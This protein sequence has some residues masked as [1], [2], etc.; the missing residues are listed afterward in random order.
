MPKSNIVVAPST[1][2][3]N[4]PKFAGLCRNFDLWPFTQLLPQ[5]TVLQQKTSEQSLLHLKRSQ[6]SYFLSALWLTAILGQAWSLLL[7][8]N[9]MIWHQTPIQGGYIFQKSIIQ[10]IGIFGDFHLVTLSI[11]LQ[12]F[13]STNRSY[14]LVWLDQTFVQETSQVV[15]RVRVRYSCT[16]VFLN[17]ITTWQYLDAQLTRAYSSNAPKTNVTQTPLQTSMAF[18]QATGGSELLMDA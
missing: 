10:Q 12:K 8:P 15:F 2:G 9:N 11:M 16:V 4:E 18:V 3:L 7:C 6:R 17:L 14:T 5:L 1:L 13:V